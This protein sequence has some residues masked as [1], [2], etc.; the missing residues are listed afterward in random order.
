M[1]AAMYSTNRTC[2]RDLALVAERQFYYNQNYA[3]IPML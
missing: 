1:Y 2:K 3:N